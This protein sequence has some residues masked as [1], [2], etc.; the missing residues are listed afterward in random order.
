LHDWFKPDN[1]S[2]D[3][4]NKLIFE[5]LDIQRLLRRSTKKF[6]GGYVMAGLIGHGDA[7]VMRDPSGIRPAFYYANEEIVVVASERPAIQTAVDVHFSKVKELKPGHALII[8]C[9]GRISEESYAD[10]LEHRACSFERIY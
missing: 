6:D 1:Y 3:E 5:N 7:F 9:D 4:I 10:P 2:S 8:K